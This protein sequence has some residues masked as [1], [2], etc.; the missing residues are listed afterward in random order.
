MSNLAGI[1]ASPLHLGLCRLGR[2]MFGKRRSR[3]SRTGAPI[4]SGSVLAGG[5]IRK[6][7]ASTGAAAGGRPPSAA[8]SK[9]KAR[10]LLLPSSLYIAAR[11]STPSSRAL[12]RSA[13][14]ADSCV[15]CRPSGLAAATSTAPSARGRRPKKCGVEDGLKMDA[16]ISISSAAGWAAVASSVPEPPADCP[17]G[18]FRLSL[19]AGRCFPAPC[20]RHNRSGRQCGDARGPWGAL[21]SLSSSLRGTRIA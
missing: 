9:T 8:A 10:R 4:S 14:A 7:M 18:R 13:W 5:A 20:I 16:V 3:C 17:E 11:R 2:F 15:Q 1:A 6:G 21:P 19:S 12:M